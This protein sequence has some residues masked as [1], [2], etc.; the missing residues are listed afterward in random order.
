MNHD[1][2][3]NQSREDEQHPSQEEKEM[4]TSSTTRVPQKNG[5]ETKPYSSQGQSLD[6]NELGPTK[7]ALV[8]NRADF[9]MISSGRLLMRQTSQSACSPNPI[10]SPPRS[11]PQ[12][13]RYSKHSDQTSEMPLCPRVNGL[14]P[15]AILIRRRN[16]G[17]WEKSRA[18]ALCFKA[19]V[20]A[21]LHMQAR[22]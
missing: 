4:E 18:G 10:V 7:E 17:D 1:N 11:C 8:T 13:S 2:P 6:Q 19:N 15:E 3:T 12:N 22:K 9:D 14:E 21:H 16:R 20:Q 5:C